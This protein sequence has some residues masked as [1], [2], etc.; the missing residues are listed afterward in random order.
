[1]SPSAPRPVRTN[2]NISRRYASPLRNSRPASTVLAYEIVVAQTASAA[3]QINIHQIA[4]PVRP[5]RSDATMNGY[6]GAT[7]SMGTSAGTPINIA[8]A[9]DSAVPPTMTAGT[10]AGLTSKD[11]TPPVMT[12]LGGALVVSLSLLT[13]GCIASTLL[14]RV[15]AD[16]SGQAIITTSLFESSVRAFDTL[17]GSRG[18]PMPRPPNVEEELPAPGQTELDRQFGTPVRIVSTRLDKAPDGGVR[19]TTIAF[20]DVTKLQM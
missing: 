8:T 17:L 16:G 1:M 5:R 18:A 6:A 14:L 19:T 11:Y 13:Q 4:S 12:R 3:A 15:R 20:E 9:Y 10:S 7:L 2:S